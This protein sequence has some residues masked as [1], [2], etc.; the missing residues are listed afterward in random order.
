MGRALLAIAPVLALLALASATACTEET[1]IVAVVPAEDDAGHPISPP[2]R[3]LTNADCPSEA[4][5]KKASCDAPAGACELFP[6]TCE[7]TERAVCGCNRVTYFND[8]LRRADGVAA[9]TEGPCPF[10]GSLECG[11]E[12]NVKCPGGAYCG[13]LSGFGGCTFNDGRG[14]CWVLPLHCPAPTTSDRWMRCGPSER[15][16]DTCTAVRDEGI[17]RRADRCP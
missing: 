17:Y 14:R 10:E 12:A 7:D 15:C 8:C 9:S 13:R 11:G 16:V 2:P 6:A 5:C 4:F 3:C 1:L